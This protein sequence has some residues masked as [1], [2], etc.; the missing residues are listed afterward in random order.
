MPTL[1]A[2][3]TSQDDTDDLHGQINNHTELAASQFV[4][5]EAAGR[6]ATTAPMAIANSLGNRLPMLIKGGQ[7]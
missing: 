2:P 4:A 7:N 1:R 3:P 5:S 6:I